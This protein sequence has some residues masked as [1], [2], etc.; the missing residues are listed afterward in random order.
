MR[1]KQI[2]I[3]KHKTRWY[4]TGDRRREDRKVNVKSRTNKFGHTDYYTSDMVFHEISI[5]NNFPP[6]KKY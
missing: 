3:I 5:K 1:I 6:D 2:I 4:F